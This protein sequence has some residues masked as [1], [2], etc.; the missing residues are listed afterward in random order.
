MNNERRKNV[1]TAKANFE[2]WRDKLTALYEELEEI[3]GMVED[4]RDEEQE[5][6]D[7]MPEGFQNGE[8]GDA[9]QTCIDGLQSIA[10]ELDELLGYIDGP[11]IDFDSYE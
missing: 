11:D 9:A 1:A 2:A 6:Y 4:A 8:K 7:N 5:Y 10:D 3:K